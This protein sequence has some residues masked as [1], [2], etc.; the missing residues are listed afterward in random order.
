VNVVDPECVLS[1]TERVALLS[2]VPVRWLTEIVLELVNVVL[3]VWSFVND[4]LKLAVGVMVGGGVF[5]S[6]SDGSFDSESE[7]VG[8][9]VCGN[10]HVSVGTSVLESVSRTVSDNDCVSSSVGENDRD[11]VN[12]GSTVGVSVGMIE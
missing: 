8:D 12:V 9:F 5:V 2:A 1:G 10:D 4:P 11:R 6:D 3:L 7:N